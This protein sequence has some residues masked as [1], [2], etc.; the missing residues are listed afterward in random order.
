[1]FGNN[2]EKNGTL[3]EKWTIVAG[4]LQRCEKSALK[5]E[6]V[7]DPNGSSICYP[8][9]YSRKHRQLQIGSIIGGWKIGNVV[10]EAAVEGLFCWIGNI[11]GRG[12]E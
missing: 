6:C 11:G 3:Q 4:L 8:K 5:D 7:T 9:S 10:G 1:M 12:K 2:I